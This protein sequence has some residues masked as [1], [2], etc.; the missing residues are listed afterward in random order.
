MEP[1][2]D[3]IDLDGIAAKM[4]SYTTIDDYLADVDA[5]IANCEIR[6][7]SEYFFLS[8]TR[9]VAHIFFLQNW[10]RKILT[11]LLWPFD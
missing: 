5:F 3:T 10:F 6:F 9:R 2:V 1:L 8:D 4:P 11:F 7:E